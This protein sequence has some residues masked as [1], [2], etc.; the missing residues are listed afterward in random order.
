M[1]RCSEYSLQFEC[2][3]FKA[4]FKEISMFL[5][6][7]Q[8]GIPVRHIYCN[9]LGNLLQHLHSVL[10]LLN[11]PV[12]FDSSDIRLKVSDRSNFFDKRQKLVSLNVKLLVLIQDYTF[13]HFKYFFLKSMQFT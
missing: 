12:T 8:L 3:V 7:N 1:F 4:L 2:L 11:D 5:I 10:N 13:N 6:I 9:N